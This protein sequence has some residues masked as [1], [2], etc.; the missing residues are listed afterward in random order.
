MRRSV[1]RTQQVVSMI[2][3]CRAAR[4]GAQSR[5]SAADLPTVPDDQQFVGRAEVGAPPDAGLR[6]TAQK[7]TVRVEHHH[8]AAGQPVVAQ[9]P[10]GGDQHRLADVVERDAMSRGERLDRGD[11]GDDVVVDVDVRRDGVEDPQRAVVQRRVAPRQKCADAAGSELGFDGVGPDPW[12]ARRAS[13]RRPGGSR[14][15]LARLAGRP[16]RRTGSRARG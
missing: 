15:S 1:C 9:L 10:A 6:R 7:R 13:R 8:G 14:P 5:R 12:R 2:Q 11:A 4:L 3:P 16:V